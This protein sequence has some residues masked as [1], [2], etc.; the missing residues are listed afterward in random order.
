[1][2]AA[3]ITRDELVEIIRSALALA[4]A[5]RW[6]GPQDVEAARSA[7]AEHGKAADMMLAEGVEVDT[8]FAALRNLQRRF[9]APSRSPE[10]TLALYTVRWALTPTGPFITIPKLGKAFYIRYRSDIIEI[11]TDNGIL[12]G[13][14][15]VM[16]LR[17]TKHPGGPRAV[18]QKLID[19]LDRKACATLTAE[20]R[21]LK[22][23]ARAT[24]IKPGL[25]SKGYHRAEGTIK[26][27]LKAKR[28]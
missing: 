5:L 17:P 10:K 14:D 21:P 18:P 8:V 24:L 3:S 25:A 19:K 13:S 28:P 22:K 27:K 12:A 16:L 11:V 4:L 15:V 26:N 2:A 23:E 1:V 9:P 20:D 6:D 7:I